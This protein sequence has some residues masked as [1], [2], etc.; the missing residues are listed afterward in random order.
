[1]EIA[2]GTS[3]NLASAANRDYVTRMTRE[4]QRAR[5]AATDE[6]RFRHGV[7]KRGALRDLTLSS[8]RE[9]SRGR[10]SRISLALTAREKISASKF[11]ERVYLRA[12][13]RASEENLR[14]LREV[15]KRGYDVFGSIAF[16]RSSGISKRQE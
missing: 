16:P 12:N 11:I 7:R 8:P 10:V 9:R 1:M 13:K 4:S 2:S 5:Y 6:T 15:D 14:V 3:R